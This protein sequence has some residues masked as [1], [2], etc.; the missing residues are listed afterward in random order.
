MAE[1]VTCRV[2]YDG[3]EFKTIEARS[4]AF[5]E[6]TA[7]LKAE[8]QI[9]E[10]SIAEFKCASNGYPAPHRFFWSVNNGPEEESDSNVKRIKIK[11]RRDDEDIQIQRQN[12]SHHPYD[13]LQ[14]F[15]TSW[16]KTY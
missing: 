4:F 7:S 16:C 13:F 8:R 3:D 15:I 5:K 10:G 12:R 1:L 11:R 2:Y 6:P 9:E 14:G